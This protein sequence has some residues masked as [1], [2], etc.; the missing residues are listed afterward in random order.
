MESPITGTGL[1]E[2]L[3]EIGVKITVDNFVPATSALTALSRILP[4]STKI[5]RLFFVKTSG[6]ARRTSDQRRP[7]HGPCAHFVGNR[8]RRSRRGNR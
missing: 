3:K 6:S 8:A 4:D 7:R 5:D 1:L 2:R